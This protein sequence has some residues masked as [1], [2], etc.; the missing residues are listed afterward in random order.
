MVCSLIS[1]EFVKKFTVELIEDLELNG[2]PHSNVYLISFQPRCPQVHRQSPH[3]HQPDTE[4]ESEE[5]LQG[6]FNAT[7]MHSCTHT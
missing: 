6:Q 3:S 4:G 2:K 5:V 7:E 1:F